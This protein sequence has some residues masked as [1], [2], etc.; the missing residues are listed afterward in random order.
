MAPRHPPHSAPRRPRPP[1]PAPAPQ[2]FTCDVYQI[3][4][5]GETVNMSHIRAHY[6]TSHE[7]INRF[8]IVPEAPA[9]VDFSAPHGRGGMPSRTPGLPDGY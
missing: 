1:T 5:V 7:T 8:A 2:A 6:F 9:A 3:P 4:G